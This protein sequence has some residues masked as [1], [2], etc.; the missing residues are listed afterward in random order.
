MTRNEEAGFGRRLRGKRDAA[1]AILTVASLLVSQAALADEGG[2]SVW[3]PG[4]FGSLAASPLQPGWSLTS[5][6]YHTS[7]SAGADVAKAREITIGQIP[8]NLNA[9]LSASLDARAD[10]GLVMPTYTFATPVFGGQFTVGAI[11]IYGRTDTSLA[12]SVTGALTN[13]AGH[14]PIL[15]LR[16]HQRLSQRLRRCVS[17]RDAALEQRRSQLHD[18]RDGGCAGR[19]LTTRHD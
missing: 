16:Q 11:G 3:L 6:Y 10:L 1:I 12:G 2:V 19:G 18:L 8:V 14:T 17:A 9:N 5:I 7:V 13:S 4:F 15:A